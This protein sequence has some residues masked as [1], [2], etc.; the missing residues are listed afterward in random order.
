MA[1]IQDEDEMNPETEHDQQF[2]IGELSREAGVSVRTIRYYISEGCRRQRKA[3][4][5][6][7]IRGRILTGCG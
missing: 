5:A 7:C 3:G 6:R 4:R 1:M 2:S